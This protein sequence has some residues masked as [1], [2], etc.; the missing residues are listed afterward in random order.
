VHSGYNPLNGQSSAPELLELIAAGRDTG[1]ES[2][3]PRSA[4]GNCA[5]RLRSVRRI[6]PSLFEFSHALTTRLDAADFLHRQYTLEFDAGIER[7]VRRRTREA[8]TSTSSCWFATAGSGLLEA[9]TNGITLRCR[10]QC[11][12]KKARCKMQNHERGREIA[13]VRSRHT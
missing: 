12:C 5:C 13:Y 10:M 2:I 9:P 11:R 7:A 3:T 4:A 8:L 6:G 1:V